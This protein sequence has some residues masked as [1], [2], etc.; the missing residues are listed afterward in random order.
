MGYAKTRGM[1]VTGQ[2]P[3]GSSAATN[4]VHV[5]YVDAKREL[6]HLT[7]TLRSDF[8]VA[9]G[10]RARFVVRPGDT[11]AAENLEKD[12]ESLLFL[13]RAESLEIDAAFEPSSATPGGVSALGMV[14]MP[15]GDLID[16]DQERARIEGQL[17]EAH[18]FMAGIE[19]KLSN[20]KFVNNAPDKVVQQQR[21]RLEETRERAGKLQDMIQTLG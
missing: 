18:K 17:A 15:L 6:V 8:G 2:L 9:P 13:L 7:R 16:V 21:D 11:T 12:R 14:F 19:K 1:L 20:E 10:L 4:S 5:D 3:V